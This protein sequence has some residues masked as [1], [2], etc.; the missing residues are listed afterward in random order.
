V[1]EEEWSELSGSLGGFDGRSESELL[2]SLEGSDDGLG[3]RTGDRDRPFILLS[4]SA[5]TTSRG[6]LAKSRSKFAASVHLGEDP[7]EARGIE[8]PGR[9]R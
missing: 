5:A 6:G 2:G 9:A 3:S 4:V 1:L 7:G 8:D